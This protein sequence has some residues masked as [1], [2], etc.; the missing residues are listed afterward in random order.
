[1]TTTASSGAAG[2]A[3]RATVAGLR[4]QIVTTVRPGLRM[5]LAAAL[6]VLLAA[7]VNVTNLM[8]TRQVARA[9]EAAIRRALGASSGRLI[10][11]RLAEGVPLAAGGGLLG[12]GLALSLI[13]ILVRFG[14][15][16]GLPRL[17]AVRVDG[18]VLLFSVALAAAMRRRPWA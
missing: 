16:S 11:D 6:L 13:E 14:P 3:V 7:C 1:M 4:D 17:D 12:V 18:P 10:A 15:A 9:R 2:P 5:L 8:L